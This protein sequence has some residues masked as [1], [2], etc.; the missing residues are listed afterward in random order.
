MMLPIALSVINLVLVRSPDHA[1][2]VERNETG[3]DAAARNFSVCMLLGVAYAASIGGIGT[4]IGTPPNLFLASFIESQFGREVSFVR[5]MAVGVPFVVVFLPIV[6]LL[7]TR[8]LFPVRL[9][10]IEGGR[11]FI[12]ESARGLGRMRKGEWVT[13]VVFSMAA[14]SWIFR[15]LLERVSVAGGHPLQGLT[16]TGIAMMAAMVLFVVPVDYKS[17]SFAMNWE[18]AV[19]LP[20][21]VLLLFGGGLSLAASIERNG[22]GEFIGSRVAGFGGLPAVALVVVVTTIVIFLTE[23]TSNTATTATFV[24]IL[25]AVSPSLGVDPYLLIVPATI[26]ASCAFMLPVATPPNALVFG[27]GHVRIDQMVRAGIWL[28]LIGI[29]LITAIS[30]AIV[31]PVLAK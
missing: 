12:V 18:T 31:A 7:N 25:A 24:P 6:W 27:S 13:L 2:E 9:R 15:P 29:V 10:A 14:G 20:W 23:L 28:N 21:G 4:L 30:F 11:E 3:D 22:V 17:R 5:W 16:D 19:R 1:T 8:V 26:A